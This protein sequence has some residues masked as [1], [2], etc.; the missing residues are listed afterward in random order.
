MP[1]RIRKCIEPIQPYNPGKPVEELERELGI[2][3]IIKLAS[4]EN[5]L[6]P[7]PKAIQVIK[8]KASDMNYYPDGSG[9]DLRKKL[10][11]IHGV[12]PEQITI[13]NGSDEIVSLLTQLILEPGDE[14]II[15][16]LAFVRY[17]MAVQAAGAKPVI[18]PA[19][20]KYHHDLPAMKKAIN[21]KTR[22]VFICNPNN[23]TG[24]MLTQAETDEF[25]QSIPDSVLVVFDE[26]YYEFVTRPDYTQSLNY[27][28]TGK[29]VMV[30]RTFSK[31]Y[32][33]AGLR[34]GYGFADAQLITDFNRV[35]TP[36]NVNRIAMFAAEAALDDQDYVV[37]C[38]NLNTEGKNY[39][40]SEM[41]KLGLPYVETEGNFILI[42]TLKNGMDIYQKMLQLGVIVRPMGMY[43]L[44]T[45]IRVTIGTM[46]ENKRFVESL[47]QVIKS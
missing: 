33:L 28:K 30:L 35:R 6:G 36:F 1:T 9:Y 45:C 25:M 26:A 8:E 46:E 21:D 11:S 13:G 10:A 32:G 15:S 19:K 18:V 29:N 39:I 34:V 27:L 3:N 47:A 7:S 4:N 31:I 42:D 22:I 23:P 20:N 40:Y 24:T 37:K 12:A 43:K 44:P 38:A 41:A 17:E 14:A 16:E 2:T 5:P